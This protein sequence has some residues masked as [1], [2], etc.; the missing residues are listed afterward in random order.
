M[1]GQY[2]L[3]NMMGTR[4]ET[5][6]QPRAVV[7]SEHGGHEVRQRVVA[8]VG[9]HVADAQALARQQRRRRRVL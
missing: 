6:L 9:G 1:N 8:E 3:R 4:A 5:H 7:Q 2:G